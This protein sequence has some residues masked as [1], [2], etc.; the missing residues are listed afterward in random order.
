M[1][2]E[3]IHSTSYADKSLPYSSHLSEA[4]PVKEAVSVSSNY[5]KEIG[6]KCSSFVEDGLP[7]SSYV[8][9]T[10]CVEEVVSVSS[11][12][13]KE[14]EIQSSYCAKEDLPDPSQLLETVPTEEQ[15]EEPKNIVKALMVEIEEKEHDAVEEEGNQYVSSGWVRVSVSSYLFE[16]SYFTSSLTH[17]CPTIDRVTS[18][19]LQI[20]TRGQKIQFFRK[21]AAS[22]TG[23]H[24]FAS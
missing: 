14:E 19:S 8:S 3:E 17:R 15:D 6:K 5:M 18:L 16:L 12:Y 22:V 24:G 20:T 13:T 10:S 23:M 9:T 11:N 2:G 7:D 1:K 4:L 21:A